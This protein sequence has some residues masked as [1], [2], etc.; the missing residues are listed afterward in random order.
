MVIA[1]ALF[2]MLAPLCSFG[3]DLDDAAAREAAIAK[4]KS[5]HSWASADCLKTRRKEQLEEDLFGVR[6][7]M[8][9]DG[10]LNESFFV[11]EVVD[12]GC[13]QVEDSLLV[14]DSID[15]PGTFGYVAVNKIT[16]MTYRLWSDQDASKDFNRLLGD[17]GV[18]VDEENGA[19][20]LAHLYRLMVT[21]PYE[22]NVV[23]DSF[24]V[25][26]LAE[27]SFYRAFRD[28]NWSKRFNAWFS[29]FK[30]SHTV[31]FDE[32]AR[33]VPE[34]WV[35]TGK[36]FV[37]FQLTIPRTKVSGQPTVAEWSI[38][39]SPSGQVL[40]NPSRVVFQ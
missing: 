35:V 37:G 36:S 12:V 2:F 3:S 5:R 23:Y 17:L 8:V 25:K 10:R 26:Q 15:H 32:V 33:K 1:L 7:E 24:Q 28:E 6:R 38:R 11:Y 34:G 18:A 30:A 29:R 39:I 27:Q 20:A 40:E 4:V 13:F 31:I 9:L 19:K 14:V 22:G 16:G 21:G